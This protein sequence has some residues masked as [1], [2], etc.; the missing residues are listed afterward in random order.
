MEL[1]EGWWYPFDFGEGI[2]EED[3]VGEM[4]W[5]GILILIM[6][7]SDWYFVVGVR[8]VEWV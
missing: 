8:K 4:R 6:K 3:G 7:R 1:G 5:D 2:G